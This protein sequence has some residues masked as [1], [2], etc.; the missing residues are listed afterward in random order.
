MWRIK[1]AEVKPHSNTD[2]ED[3]T[4]NSESMKIAINDAPFDVVVQIDEGPADDAELQKKEDIEDE[5]GKLTLEEEAEVKNRSLRRNVHSLNV[6]DC[7]KYQEADDDVKIQKTDV[8]KDFHQVGSLDKIEKEIERLL[9]FNR[10]SDEP[11]S[12]L[13]YGLPGAGK[14]Y[15]LQRVANKYGFPSKVI[16]TTQI[17][18]SYVGESEK[19]LKKIF[20]E[21]SAKGPTLLLLDEIDGLM[22]QRS[23]KS[24]AAEEVRKGVKNLMLNILSGS[25]ALPNLFLYFTTNFPWT[26]DKAFLD[27]MTTTTKVDLPDKVEQ[28]KFFLEKV[29][30][31]SYHTTITYEE[32]CTLETENFNY[33]Q[34]NQLFKASTKKLQ[35][36][37]M[38]AP[39]R[40]KISTDPIKI[41][42]CYCTTG[43]CERYDVPL[44]KIPS[45]QLRV[46]TITLSDV[47]E[48]QRKERIRSTMNQEDFRKIDHFEAF[49]KLPEEDDR[50]ASNNK[51]ESMGHF[52]CQGEISEIL[53]F[54]ITGAAVLLT[55]FLLANFVF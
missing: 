27:R 25:E 18:D 43:N 32:F 31:K 50:K 33:R 12:T 21:A 8:G 46:G 53:G 22:S 4:P 38:N 11:V 34:M 40:S 20:M 55:V 2:V 23:E 15:L 13:L 3:P 28:Y 16:S 47:A 30:A 42:G 49:G 9:I 41:V 37:T 48:A 39:H 24:G 14:S 7:S 1:K 45:K 54:L 29:E 44:M 26:L 51:E 5:D 52:N 10:D 19:K 36:F 6:L 17:L 35:Y